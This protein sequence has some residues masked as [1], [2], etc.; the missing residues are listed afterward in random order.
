M[1]CN[2]VMYLFRENELIADESEPQNEEEAGFF[3]DDEDETIALTGDELDNI[4][5]TADITEETGTEFEKESVLEE[6]AETSDTTDADMDHYGFPEIDL[7]IDQE[8]ASPAELELEPEPEPELLDDSD[9]E[10]SIELLQEEEEEE[11]EILQDEDLTGD[12]SDLPEATISEDEDIDFGIEEID[13][14]QELSD[15]SEL[16]SLDEEEIDI[17]IDSDES[18][19]SNENIVSEIEPEQ[20]DQDDDELD[21]DLLDL[22]EPEELDI[23][24]VQEMD[25]PDLMSDEDLL[26]DKADILPMQEEE[27]EE[28]E[29][30]EADES[31]VELSSDD[32]EVSEPS[33]SFPIDMELPE[34]QD[35][36]C[37]DSE[38][39]PQ[40]LREE[41]KSVLSY[42]DHLLESL[43]DEKIEEFANSEHFEVYKRLFSELGLST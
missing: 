39:I 3:E 29:I 17:E 21:I 42:M 12:E 36:E 38:E 28:E 18:P 9:S 25:V 35:D 27:E 40:Q 15:L 23:E 34:M 16:D 37:P 30:Y 22:D 5:N 1:L 43:P 7:E 2:L 8:P 32:P 20:L 10:D 24:E 6:T 13:L 41:I 31:D 33:E 11:I 19:A 26:V 14:D 4:L